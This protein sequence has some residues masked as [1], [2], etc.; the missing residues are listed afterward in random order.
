MQM[1]RLAIILLA[2]ITL[3][4]AQTKEEIEKE[5]RKYRNTWLGRLPMRSFMNI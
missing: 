3:L 2:G 1:I 4:Q 5:I